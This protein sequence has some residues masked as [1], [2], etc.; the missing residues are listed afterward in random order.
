MAHRTSSLAPYEVIPPGRGLG[1]AARS[2]VG[3]AQ[4]G[5]TWLLTGSL[6]ALTS[7]EADTGSP[8]HSTKGRGLLETSAAAPSSGAAGGGLP[9]WATALICPPAGPG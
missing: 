6:G 8:S 2:G 7:E 3:L 4:S 9:W 1:T 5:D